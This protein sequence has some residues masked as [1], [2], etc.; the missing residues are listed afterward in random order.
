MLLVVLW[1]PRLTLFVVVNND[2]RGLIDSVNDG[3]TSAFMWE[4][5][6]TKPFADAGECRFIGSV[7]TPWPSWLIAAHPSDARC[8]PETLKTFLHKLSEYVRVFDS[9]EKRENENVDFIVKMWDY[10][11]EDVKAWMKTVKYPADCAQ[12][13]ENVITD[14]LSYVFPTTC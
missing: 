11:E 7:P 3:S 2:I 8:P 5:F 6:T 9:A 12:I 1:R 4:W 10:K 13:P 14:T